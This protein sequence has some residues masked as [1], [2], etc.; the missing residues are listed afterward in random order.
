MARNRDNA[1]R[2]NNTFNI[3]NP[4]QNAQEDG[5]FTLSRT[6]LEK[7]KANLYTLLFTGTGERV[8]MPDFG[9]RLKYMLFANMSE[10]MYVSI[11]KDI[12]EKAQ[13][14]IPEIVIQKI[15]FGDELEDRE[16]N[17]ISLKITFA[18]RADEKIQDYIEIETGV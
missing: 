12:R 18:L 2:K 1:F 9:T 11:E 17:K 8:M 10:T 15:E 14:W 6:S 16:N 7:Y 5:V 4:I 3:I 13:Y